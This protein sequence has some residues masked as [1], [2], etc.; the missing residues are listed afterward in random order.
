MNY[1]EMT[2]TMRCNLKESYWI[3]DTEQTIIYRAY[4]VDEK[5][6]YDR[7]IG[8][9]YFIRTKKENITK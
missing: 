5:G 1:V 9:C 8:Y 2:F 7:T 3:F 4:A 6:K